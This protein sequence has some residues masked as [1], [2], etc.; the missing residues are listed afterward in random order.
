MHKRKTARYRRSTQTT[1]GT[2]VQ[3]RAITTTCEL[4]VAST[5]LLA[6]TASEKALGNHVTRPAS[7]PTHVDFLSRQLIGALTKA[8]TCV[9][10]FWSTEGP[11]LGEDRT[12]VCSHSIIGAAELARGQAGAFAAVCR[13]SPLRVERST[14]RLLRGAR[15]AYPCDYQQAKRILPSGRRLCVV[16]GH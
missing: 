10:R 16:L 6:S 14:P 12:F 5:I 7:I 15:K 3:E 4:A 11:L 9:I 2:R 1:V 13:A 8:Q